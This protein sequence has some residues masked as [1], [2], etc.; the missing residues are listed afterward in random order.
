V[1]VCS[2]AVVSDRDIEIAVIEILSVPNAPLPT[3]GLIYRHLEKKMDCC[4]CAPLAVATI[5]SIVER[6][7]RDGRVC[8]CACA[9]VKSR[10]ARLTARPSEPPP[11]GVP[12]LLAAE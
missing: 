10:L 7:E 12:T 5:Y 11:P 6:L 4:G 9:T 8:P 1:I 2:C 3:P